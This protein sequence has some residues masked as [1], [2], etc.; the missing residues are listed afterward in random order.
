M[1]QFGFRS[2]HSTIHAVLS[3]VDKIQQAIENNQFSCRVFLDL[4]KA[5][6]TVNHNILLNKLPHYGIRGIINTWFA[7]YLKGREQTTEINN[8]ISEKQVTLC[9]VPQGLVLGPLPF[10]IYINICNATN[11]LKIF[12]FAD[13]TN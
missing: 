5:F 7:S 3:I 10:L 4:S 9:G 13:D 2:R 12:L 11:E 1:N 6:D 8:K